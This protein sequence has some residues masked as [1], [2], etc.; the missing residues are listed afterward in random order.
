M[1]TIRAK[2]TPAD[3]MVERFDSIF[4]RNMIEPDVPIGGDRRRGG[5]AKYKWHNSKGGT[6][7]EKLDKKNK[8]L[9]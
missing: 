9:R 4:R 3:L 2:A 1:R 6:G 7:A 8:K 5:K